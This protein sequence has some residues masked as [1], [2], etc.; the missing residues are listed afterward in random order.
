[1]WLLDVNLPTGLVG[2]LESYGI[3]CDTTA[4]RSSREATNG[5]L[6]ELAFV[7]GFRVILTRDRAFGEAARR[8]LREHPEMAVVIVTL[9]QARSAAFL[10]AFRDRWSQ[11]A[12]EPIAGVAIEWP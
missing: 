6:T 3:T 10:D 11:R 1:M 12:I 5:V 9:R 4:K 8:A 7:A 2:V